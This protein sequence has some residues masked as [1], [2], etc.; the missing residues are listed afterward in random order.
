[1]EVSCVVHS[2]VDRGDLSFVEPLNALAVLPQTELYLFVFWHK[3][4][5]DSV[6]FASV[7][8]ALVAAAVHPGVN[9]KPVLFV[10]L[11]LALIHPAVI[12]DVD[13]VPLHVIIVP[14]TFIPPPVQPGVYS[15]PA[16]FIL[17]PVPRILASIRPLVAADAVFAAIRVISF[18]P[19]LVS[20]GLNPTAVL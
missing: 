2:L 5:A 11:V 3:V 4:S 9:T 1:M 14:L 8:V 13:A 12:P 19:A 6:L 7:P 18:V 15:E 16:D 20:P 17:S 10:I